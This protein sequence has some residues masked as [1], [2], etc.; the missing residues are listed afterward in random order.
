MSI[1]IVISFRLEQQAWFRVCDIP[2]VPIT[3]RF[4]IRLTDVITD[5]LHL[6]EISRQLCRDNHQHPKPFQDI[7]I[8][9]LM[10]NMILAPR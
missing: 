2:M 8:E 9:F 6:H 5:R 3:F 4:I 1:L 10:G 7:Y